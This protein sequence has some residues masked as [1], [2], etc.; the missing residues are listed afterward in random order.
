M[1]ASQDVIDDFVEEGKE[2]LEAIES[3]LDTASTAKD[4]LSLIGKQDI[5]KRMHSI[6]GAAAY[7]GLPA[8]QQLATATETLLK[9]LRNDRTE[10]PIEALEP[11]QLATKQMTKLMDQLS[12]SGN[13]SDGPMV[14]TAVAILEELTA[15]A[16]A[17]QVE[18][19][20]SQEKS[21]L[22]VAPGR[23]SIHRKPSPTS[24]QPIVFSDTPT[25]RHLTE[26]ARELVLVRNRLVHSGGTDG[27]AMADLDDITSRLHRGLVASCNRSLSELITNLNASSKLHKQEVLWTSNSDSLQSLESDSFES[28]EALLDFMLQTQSSLPK[29]EVSV[30]VSAPAHQLLFTLTSTVP[31]PEIVESTLQNSIAAFGGVLSSDSESTLSIRFPLPTHVFRGLRVTVSERSFLLPLNGIRGILPAPQGTGTLNGVEFQGQAIPIVSMDALLGQASSS[32]KH[33]LVICEDITSQPYAL[34]VDSCGKVEELTVDETSSG[35]TLQFSAGLATDMAGEGLEILDSIAI[36]ATQDLSTA[37]SQLLETFP[38]SEEEKIAVAPSAK[39]Y[40]L[41]QGLEEKW[42]AF[43]THTVLKIDTLATDALIE[44]DGQYAVL[45]DGG[46]LPLTVIEPIPSQLPANG[47]FLVVRYFNA[48][49]DQRGILMTKVTDLTP[50][51]TELESLEAAAPLSGHAEFGEHSCFLLDLTS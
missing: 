33:F 14:E 3:T 5:L 8:I 41:A 49:E 22:L 34:L 27:L 17:Q 20:I 15:K 7:C 35:E 23:S 38:K 11:L 31:L 9:L 25:R 39:R 4:G 45:I 18:Q 46:R 48:Q 40:L 13:C 26:M 2:H 32:D 43:D 10:S 12:T 50:M 19:Q 6:K 47:T 16:T 1:I 51:T 36:A 24:S 29:V 37:R 21:P 42:Y 30:A 44:E 28:V